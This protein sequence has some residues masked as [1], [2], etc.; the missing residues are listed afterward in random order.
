ML[1][2]RHLH[3]DRL[4]ECYVTERSGEPVDPRIAEHLADCEP[5]AVRYTELAGFMDGLSAQA[6]VET[7]AVFTADRLRAQQQQIA[8]R[9]EHLGHAAR[10]IS[11]P[12]PFSGDRLHA[13]T[14]AHARSRWVATAAAAGLFIGVAL[15]ASFEWQRHVRVGSNS[16]ATA[17]SIAPARLMPALP[18]ATDGN[19]P[20][21]DIAADDAFL[22]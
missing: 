7:D 4:F 17:R 2:A 19:T 8:R 12:R 14:P 15:G 6:D 18:V 1:R 9:I 3:E 5:C 20:S 13:S 21:P 22:S 11:F 10:V 16:V